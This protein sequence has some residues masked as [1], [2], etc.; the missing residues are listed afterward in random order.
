MRAGASA[1]TSPTKEPALTRIGLLTPYNGNNLGDGTIQTAVIENL[2]RRDSSI[3]FLGITLDP[4]DTA[5]RH[6]IPAFPITGL[7]VPFYSEALLLH[8][9]EA[10]WDSVPATEPATADRPG[11]LRHLIKTM[12]LVGPLL[13]FLVGRLRVLR[14]LPPEAH[15]LWRSFQAVRTLDLLLVSGGGQLD[16]EFGGPWGH[17]YVLFRWAMLSR[18][19]GTRL[20]IASV[21]AHHMHRPL[22]RFFIKAALAS[23]SYRSYR[24]PGSQQQLSRWR[25]TTNDHCVPDMALSLPVREA[26]NERSPGGPAVVGLSPM[27]YGH[28]RHWPTSRAG[29]HEQ[30]SRRLAEF[31]RWLLDRGYR[32]L[33][34][35]SSAADRVA[36]ADLRARLLEL[37]GPEEARRIA[38]PRVQTVDQFFREVA[39]ADYVVASRLHGVMMSHMLGKPVLAI[40]F[41]RKVDAHM[42]SMGQTRYRVDIGGFEVADLIERFTALERNGPAE[43][44]TIDDR[45]A[46]SRQQ[47]DDQYEA[48][49]NLAGTARGRLTPTTR[50]RVQ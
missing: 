28:A 35:Q 13:R 20:A 7:S 36:V 26:S 21:G 5:T 44:V 12:P 49:L 41:D 19:A 25:F 18:L 29:L 42:E 17:P 33:L 1:T 34:F 39:A 6:R 47:L 8:C 32:L 3:E 14:K 24:D 11:S 30:Y 37:A 45:V 46:A 16:E 23:A 50:R 27:I 31:A 2:R 9:T 38:E 22:T 15:H 4:E 48:L 40:S 43:R 10:A